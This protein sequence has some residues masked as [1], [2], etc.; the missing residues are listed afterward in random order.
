M[1]EVC[2]TVQRLAAQGL[3]VHCLELGLGRVNLVSPAGRPMME[4][5]AAAADF[6]NWQRA[7]LERL[8][9]VIGSTPATSATPIS[10]L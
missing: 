9:V 7:E 1:K 5:L 4:V 10:E 8:D 6:E 2:A 3:R